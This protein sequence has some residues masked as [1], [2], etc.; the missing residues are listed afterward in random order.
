MYRYKNIL[1]YCDLNE[2]DDAVID[3]AGKVT[4]LANSEKVT[5]C[6]YTLKTEIPSELMTKYP[7]LGEPIEK[8]A[9]QRVLDAI[10]THYSGFEKTHVTTEI[11]EGK[12][13]YSILRKAKSDDVDL[14]IC[15]RNTHIEHLGERLSRKAPCS[16]CVIPEGKWSDFRKVLV[17][18]DFSQY[19]LDALDVGI[20]FS[21]AQG[22]ESIDCKHI[23]EPVS[24]AN[25]ATISEE[26]IQEMNLEHAKDLMK[27]FLE[28]I[29]HRGLQIN[30]EVIDS[31]V[32]GPK[33]QSIIKNTGYQLLVMGCRGK[34]AIS[35]LL[36]G[37][38]AEDVIRSSNIPII[39][40]KQ[41][42]TGRSFIENL[43]G[44]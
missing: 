32:S 35:S 31:Y 25:R 39:A 18:V 12:T 42:G 41:K 20:A 2:N 26:K 36:L 37:S 5:F 6:H 9:Q 14:I 22:L 38:T 29:D 11:S 10:D 21:S 24:G 13:L 8:L 3:F 34:D 1:V 16:V 33:F 23:C 28:S 15:G 43:L 30:S 4:K 44:M 40:V 19:S 17:P 27:N 7:W